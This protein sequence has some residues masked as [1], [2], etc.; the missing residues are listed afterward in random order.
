MWSGRVGVVSTELC[1]ASGDLDERSRGSSVV[2][3]AEGINSRHFSVHSSCSQAMCSFSRQD[4]LFND[5]F[6]I[7]EVT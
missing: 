5:Y 4:I 6:S 1:V 3:L 2:G 7:K